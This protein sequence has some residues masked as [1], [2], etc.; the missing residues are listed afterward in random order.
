[1]ADSNVALLARLEAKPGREDE[2]RTL[3]E[4][5]L[6]LARQ[7]DE[8][9]TWFAFRI[10]ESTFGIFDT[11]AAEAGREAHLQGRIAEALMAQAP[12]L[13]AVDPVIEKADVLA[14]LH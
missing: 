10:D 12:E 8:T 1:M 9:L 7:E 5:A 14:S 3:L 6:D 11:F 13:L 2:V 4:S